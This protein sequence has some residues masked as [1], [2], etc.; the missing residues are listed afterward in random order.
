M[1][2]EMYPWQEVE[3]RYMAYVSGVA[4]VRPVRHCLEAQG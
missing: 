4:R 1:Y 2:T 3:E